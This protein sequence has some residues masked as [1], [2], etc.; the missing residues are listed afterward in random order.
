MLG[1]RSRRVV[2]A[3]DGQCQSRNCPW[4]NPCIHRHS[5]FWKG[6]FLDFLFYVRY[7]I[8][9]HLPVSGDAGIEPRTVATLSSTDRS[10]NHSARSRPLSARSYPH[11]ARTHPTVFWGRQMKQFWI[12]DIKSRP[13]ECKNALLHIRIVNIYWDGILGHQFEKRLES[14]APCYSQSLLLAD[15]TDNHTLLW[16]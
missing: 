16:F 13:N 9:H 8:L 10:S 15:F 4:F 12:R 3:S 5:A 7:S 1:M 2:R 6:D 14:F 11:S